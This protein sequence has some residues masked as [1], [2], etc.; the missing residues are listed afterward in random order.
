MKMA[1][2]FKLSVTRLTTATDGGKDST[3]GVKMDVT[4]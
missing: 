4:I 1:T 2:N 3:D